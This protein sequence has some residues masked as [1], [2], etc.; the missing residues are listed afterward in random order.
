MRLTPFGDARDV[1]PFVRKFVWTESLIEGGFTWMIQLSSAGWNEWNDALIGR[2]ELQVRLKFQTDT[3]ESTPWR[4]AVVDTSKISY[5]STSLT[6][7]IYGADKRLNM[8][9]TDRTRAWPGTTVAD[10]VR[11]IGEEW[12]FDVFVE[13][14]K[15]STDRWQVRENDWTFLAR[16]V[17]SSA[18]ASG[19]GDTYV[20][21]DEDKLTLSAPQLQRSSDRRHSLQAVE[22]RVDRVTLSYHGR[23]VDRNGGATLRVVSYDVDKKE[24]RTFDVD[25]AA[26]ESQP[27][28]ARRVPRSQDGGLRVFPG[29]TG[30]PSGVEETAR[31]Q[32]G[33]Y[34]PRYFAMRLDTRPD[35]TLKPGMIIEVQGSLDPGQESPFLGRFVCLE[36]THELTSG[37]LS[38]K[39]TGGLI[40]SAICYRREAYIGDD[41]PSGSSAVRAGTRDRYQFGQEQTQTTTVVAEVLE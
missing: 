29:T 7:A 10:V 19:R 8:M 15:H 6:F 17:D 24:A 4:T 38:D 11:R 12:G 31:A 28:L 21:L 39:R 22:N 18:V 30:E 27:A 23:E 13:R 20:W 2:V 40:T 35:L 14:T 5:R 1:T 3:V 9:Q 25:R 33:S 16:L 36:V 41:E 34:G 37:D 26:T 32:W